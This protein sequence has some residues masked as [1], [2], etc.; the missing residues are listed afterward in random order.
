MVFVGN[1]P[2]RGRRVILRR[3]APDG[4]AFLG[5]VSGGREDSD[6]K[7][8]GRFQQLGLILIVLGMLLTAEAQFVLRAVP[9]VALGSA[10]VILGIVCLGLERAVVTRSPLAALLGQAGSAALAS[11]IEEVGVEATAVYLPATYFSARQPRALLRL[12]QNLDD[13]PAPPLPS[14]LIIPVGPRETDLAMLVSTVGS[15]AMS[16]L[17]DQPG[18][19]LTAMESLA[20]QLLVAT[21]EVA[22]RVTFGQEE[23]E[24]LV[25]VEGIRVPFPAMAYEKVLGSPVAS[26]LAALI[27]EGANRPVVINGESTDQG[28]MQVRFLLR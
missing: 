2:Q 6:P 7:V 17:E 18:P 19:S 15:A 5:G 24:V 3:P 11:L 12:G 27:A 26:I 14:R 9:M 1:F 8:A 20:N 28:V 25:R 22:S 10:T 4:L 13:L 23:A 16:Q 21:L